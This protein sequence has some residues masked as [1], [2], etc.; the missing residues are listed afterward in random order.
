MDT[1]FTKT[2]GLVIIAAYAAFVALLTFVSYRR[3]RSKTWFLLANRQITG[4]QGPLTIAATWIW[5]PALFVSAQL[6]YEGGWTKAIYWLVPNCACLAVFAWF[7]WKIRSRYP[8]GF[9]LSDSMRQR[10]SGRVQ[11][12]YGFQLLGLSTAVFAVQLLAG[13]LV[14]S[15][16]TGLSFV[17]VTIIMALVPLVSS[18]IVG[19]RVSVVTDL[20]KMVTLAGGGLVLAIWVLIE[21]GG[22]FTMNGVNGHAPLISASGWTLF[23]TFGLPTAIA[24]FSGPFGDQAFYQR[25]FAI[26]RP[27]VRSSFVKAALLFTIVP[28]SFMVLGGAAAGSGLAVENTQLT[29][30]AAIQ[31]WLPTWV[32]FPFLWIVLSGLMSTLDSVLCAVASIAGHDVAEQVEPGQEGERHFR[33]YSRLAMV[34]VAV[35]ALAISNIHGITIVYLAIFYGTLR[36]ATMVPTMV[37]LATRSALNERAVFW[38]VLAAIVIAMP[39]SA[40]GNLSTPVRPGYILAGIL[41]AIG[42]SGIGSVALSRLLPGH[43]PSE[44]IPADPEPVTA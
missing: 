28:V 15:A 32:V 31:T 14:I 22:E 2:E 9:T 19:L 20:T 16:L 36:A 40:I 34:A 43:A 18:F 41:C 6:L 27:R 25:A 24:V 4:R 39:L 13:G 3:N 38:S 8:D 37:T 30:L 29:N 35:G 21:N 5:A 17:S 1:V 11:A 23:W 44:Q 7:A 33:L 12:L 26:E 42:I 10:Y